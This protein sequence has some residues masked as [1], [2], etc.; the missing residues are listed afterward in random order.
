M[1]QTELRID[2]RKG[3]RRLGGVRV[4]LALA[5]ASALSAA[6]QSA[7][8]DP[9][10]P[11]PPVD[12]NQEPP[13]DWSAWGG[14][15]KLLG[16]S[17]ADITSSWSYSSD[18]TQQ[19]QSGQDSTTVFME[20]EVPPPEEFIP[21]SSVRWKVV[22]ANAAASRMS[23]Y[24][25]YSLGAGHWLGS[26]GM[27]QGSY[28]GPLSLRVEPTLSFSLRNGTGQFSTLREP[29]AA[30]GADSSGTVTELQGDQVVTRSYSEVVMQDPS[31]H[32]LEH[33][34]VDFTAPKAVGPFSGRF[35]VE[36]PSGDGSGRGQGS[37]QRTASF[38]FWPDW[39]DLEV[40]VEVEDSTQPGVSYAQWRPEGNLENPDVGGPRPLRLKATLRPKAENPTPE[41]LAATPPVRRFR[42]ELANVSREPGVCMN[43]PLPAVTNGVPDDPEFDLRFIATVPEAMVLSPKKS[44]AGVIPLPGEDPDL[45]SAWVLLEC[46]DFGAHAILQVYAD[47]ADGRV[48][49]GHMRVGEEKVY[50]ITIPE[51]DRDTFVA[52][53]WR[54]DNQVTSGDREDL[55]DQPTGD[56][57]KGDGFSVYE[58]YRGFRMG[59][60][61]LSPDPA[62]KDLFLRNY[63]GGPV[64]AACKVLELK[65]REGGRK[66]LRVHHE[67]ESDE[68]HDT[69]IMNLNRNAKS[70]RSTDEPQY[71]LVVV[72]S[73][74]AGDA[75][76]SYA[77]V[78][79]QPWRPRNTRWVV[80][81][82]KDNT[83]ETVVHE[84]AHAIGVE[85]HGDIDYNAR[86]LVVQFPSSD[87]TMLRRFFEQRMTADRETGVLTPTGDPVPIRVFREGQS[88]ET[89]PDQSTN[90]PLPAPTRKFIGNRGGQNSGQEKCFM[91]YDCAT[92]YVPAGRPID[93]ITFTSPLVFDF[94]E[95][96]I[97]SFCQSC[98]GTGVNPA[99]FG[100]ATA[101]NCFFQLC[102]RDTAP[103][104][105]VAT[106]RC[107][108]TP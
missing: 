78:K 84:L 2:R 3:L 52:R 69:R 16:V 58:E 63:N 42:F 31:R 76:I 46:F 71:G 21:G 24:S 82:P 99:R 81:H 22:S 80:I 88:L 93:R 100:H 75:I 10:P 67:F 68:W 5:L 64:V 1:E 56:G 74:A 92:A 48:I 11:L 105:P 23:S 106:G 51:R 29:V 30:W 59:G 39:S 55:D 57:Q 12:P 45:P 47:L 97:Y 108:N 20:L 28:T 34:S 13:A 18:T 9:L 65:T 62:V 86:W 19:R 41:Q 14:V 37:F 89:L 70:P 33:S 104:R 72:P 96:E 94:S 26:E 7:D 27:T 60:K 87:G 53:K 8:E 6:G 79:R 50:Q 35:F 44:K 36:G 91:R 61:H 49:V 25:S 77:D 54:E 43:W 107:S 95:G 17:Q 101:G 85:H 103:A 15:P 90:A 32:P 102:V 98:R 4:L 38:Q 40:R 66:G 73:L 83:V